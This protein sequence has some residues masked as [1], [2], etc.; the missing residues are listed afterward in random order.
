VPVV[1]TV[2]KADPPAKAAPPPA[3]APTGVTRVSVTTE[4]AGIRVLVDGKP[5]GN[6]PLTLD[7]LAPGRHV[8]TLQAP[9]GSIKRTIKVEAGKT[10]NVDV[11]V[12]SGFAVISVPFVV[13]IAENGRSLGT[14]EDQIILGPGRHDLHLENSELGYRAT[15]AVDIEPGEVARVAVDPRGSA[16]INAVPWAE[17]YIDGEKAGETPLANVPVRLG[18]R[19]IV[20][21]NPQFPERRIVTTIKAGSPATISVDFAKD[22]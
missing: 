10:V 16:N 9:G 17:V 2:R 1:S 7:T 20:F 6:S 13:Q 5:A 4:P 21:K 15:Q 14:S 12:F 18:V 22:K 3:A 11:P 19:E 8:L